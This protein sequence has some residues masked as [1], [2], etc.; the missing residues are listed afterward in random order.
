VTTSRR[1]RDGH[2]PSQKIRLDQ[3]TR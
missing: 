2:W 3:G 1:G